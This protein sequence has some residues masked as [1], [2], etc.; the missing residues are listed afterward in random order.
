MRSNL[1][2]RHLAR[3]RGL[4]PAP[5]TTTAP[6]YRPPEEA[7]RLFHLREKRLLRQLTDV[8]KEKI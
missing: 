7:L 3:L 5:Q 4:T 6:A 2:F 1:F 8:A